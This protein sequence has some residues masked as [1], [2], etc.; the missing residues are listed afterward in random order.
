[1]LGHS[2]A[3]FVHSV[4]LGSVWHPLSSQ[5]QCCSQRAANTVVVAVPVDTSRVDFHL[6]VVVA[7]LA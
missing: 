7:T 3:G 2:A 4:Q 6:S 1:M 5:F